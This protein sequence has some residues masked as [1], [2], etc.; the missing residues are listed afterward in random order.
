MSDNHQETLT[1]LAELAK[2]GL[3]LRIKDGKWSVEFFRDEPFTGDTL[4]DALV[5][6]AAN[7]ITR[8]Q[9]NIARQEDSIAQQYASLAKSREYGA[10]LQSLL[11]SV[12][13][14]SDG[15]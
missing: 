13:K 6:L 10:T 15:Q 5:K 9:C 11:D 4:R 3:I 7:T 2:G 14:A 12:S 8:Q 1:L